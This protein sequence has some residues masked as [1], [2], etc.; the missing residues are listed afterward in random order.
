MSF[1]DMFNFLSGSQPLHGLK[2]EVR[3]S[4]PAPV[5]DSISFTFSIPSFGVLN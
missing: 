4:P 3:F 1:A 2:G 5:G